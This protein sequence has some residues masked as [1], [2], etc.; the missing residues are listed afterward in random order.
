MTG[1][2]KSLCGK[3]AGHIKSLFWQTSS[4]QVKQMAILDL[5]NL[6]KN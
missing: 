4:P 3:H 6:K 2:I 1:H 5:D